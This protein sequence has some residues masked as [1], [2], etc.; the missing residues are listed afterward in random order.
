MNPLRGSQGSLFDN[1]RANPASRSPQNGGT[2][3]FG[4]GHPQFEIFAWHDAYKSCQ[5]YFVNHAQHSGQVQSVAAFVNIKLPVQ[6][7]ENAIWNI[8]ATSPPS[9]GP[10]GYVP[11]DVFANPSFPRPQPAG[12]PPHVPFIS[13][14]PYIRRLVVTGFDNDG[15]MHG[16]F[17]EDWRRGIGSL[18]EI[19]RRNYLFAAK[20]VGWAKVK[21]QYDMSPEETV[22]FMKPLQRTVLIE[23]EAAE[24]TWSEWLA[25]E[26]WMIGP[27]APNARDRTGSGRRSYGADQAVPLAEDQF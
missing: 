6:W 2:S 9:A 26:D 3:Q 27:R 4:E 22:P 14:I 16:F 5:R 8:P 11:Q 15:I 17:G 18:H 23:I 21:Y 7:R 12:P 10:G 19:E 24:K 20:S 1:P 13:L 25:M